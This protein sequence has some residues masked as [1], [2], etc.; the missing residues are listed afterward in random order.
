MDALDHYSINVKDPLDAKVM[1]D[2][3]NG[4]LPWE[5]RTH[6]DVDW[7]K[8]FFT[9]PRLPSNIY[10]QAN[11]SSST[12]HP[13]HGR[14]M[15]YWLPNPQPYE[16]DVRYG[17]YMEPCGNKHKVYFLELWY[18]SLEGKR[19]GFDEHYASVKRSHLQ[20]RD[21]SGTFVDWKEFDRDRDDNPLLASRWHPIMDAVEQRRIEYDISS[22]L[23]Q[24]GVVRFDEPLVADHFYGPDEMPQLPK[25]RV[26]RNP[27]G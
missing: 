1:V 2:Y 25:L 21:R 19:V 5:C 17:F 12:R 18:T 15:K 7:K 9:N 20:I 16:E 13:L 22:R 10:D 24:N 11:S 14:L 23:S 26:V 8:V 4:Y 6:V 3:L 27:Q